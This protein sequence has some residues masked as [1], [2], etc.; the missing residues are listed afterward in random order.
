MSYASQQ[1]LIERFGYQ[2]LLN[3]SDRVGAGI[4]GAGVIDSA[5]LDADAEINSYLAGRYNLP[6]TQVSQELLRIACDITRYR[7]YDIL[8]TEAVKIRYD[9]AIKKL[10]DVSKGV[11]S[12]GMDQV[13][14]PVA[15]N[16]GA[17]INSSV[18]DFGRPGRG[19]W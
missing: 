1:A 16:G 18:K 10:R 4:I 7:L 14:Q 17:V 19:G 12:L 2:E 8:A 11:A 9:D 15:V 13:N 6:L 3:L 5:L